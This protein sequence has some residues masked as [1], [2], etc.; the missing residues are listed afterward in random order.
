M[1]N[2]HEDIARR[3]LHVVSHFTEFFSNGLQP[4]RDQVVLANFIEIRLDTS[5]CHDC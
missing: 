3:T 4:F 1:L 5:G 2:I